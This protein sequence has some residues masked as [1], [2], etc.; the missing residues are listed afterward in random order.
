M[1]TPVSIAS[2]HDVLHAAAPHPRACYA[3]RMHRGQP[4]GAPHTVP[5][6][7]TVLSS[8]PVSASAPAS[9]HVSL[10]Q[11]EDSNSVPTTPISNFIR[12][13]LRPGGVNRVNAEP[14]G[15]CLR[16][17][18]S[19]RIQGDTRPPPTASHALGSPTVELSSFRPR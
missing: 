4:D 5:V 10:R 17:Q 9:V 6:S 19:A 1:P 13:N 7:A 3:T 11:T 2:S 16:A 12:P 18:D 15:I 14:G 8:A